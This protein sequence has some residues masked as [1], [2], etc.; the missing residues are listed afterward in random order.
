[1]EDEKVVNLKILDV[2]GFFNS[3]SPLKRNLVREEESKKQ[4]ISF[5]GK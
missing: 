1:M 5:E 3:E 2:H 4:I